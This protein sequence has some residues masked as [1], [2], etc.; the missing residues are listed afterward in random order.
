MRRCATLPSIRGRSGSGPSR[1]RIEVTSGAASTSHTVGPRRS[2]HTPD[3]SGPSATHRMRSAPFAGG[4][5]PVPP[6]MVPYRPRCTCRTSP[7]K[8]ANRC[9]PY[10][11]TSWRTRPSS[12]AAP[13]ANRPWGLVTCTGRPAKI[14]CCSRARRYRVCP[15]GTGCPPGVVGGHSNLLIAAQGDLPLGGVL[16]DRFGIAGRYPAGGEPRLVHVR[17]GDVA[18]LGHPPAHV[19]PVGVELPALSGRVE[20]PVVRRGV[21]AGAGDPLPAVVVAGQVTVDQV[22]QEV[23]GSAPPVQVQ[24]LDQER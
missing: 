5:S 9:F 18:Q 3:P 24:V 19:V 2:V 22:L 15:S 1:A 10:E 23:P 11:K 6:A 17:R 20:H 14:C 13:A 12:S 4:G 8:S 21:G 16:D 7:P